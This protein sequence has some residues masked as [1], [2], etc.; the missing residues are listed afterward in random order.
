MTTYWT[1]MVEYTVEADTEEEVWDKWGKE[2]DVTYECIHSI[3]YS[4]EDD[5]DA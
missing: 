5:D 2:K 1:V 4:W 3:D